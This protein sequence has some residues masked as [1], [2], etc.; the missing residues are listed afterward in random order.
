MGA[1]FIAALL[2][3]FQAFVHERLHVSGCAI[4]A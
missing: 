3:R 4:I 1:R 2:L